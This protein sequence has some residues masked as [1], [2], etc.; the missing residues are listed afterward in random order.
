MIRGVLSGVFW[1]AV[2]VGLLAAVVSL[3][4]PLPRAPQVAQT[5][6]EAPAVP[7][8]AP[9]AAP[10]PEAVPAPVVE[11]VPAPATAAEPAPVPDG[12]ADPADAPVVMA[13][14]APEPEDS[15]APTPEVSAVASPEPAPEPAQPPQVLALPPQPQPAPVTGATD[16]PVPG[17]ADP[18]SAS[19]A[20]AGPPAVAAAD[21]GQPVPDAPGRP[22]LSE[23]PASLGA[24][25]SLGAV[26]PPLPAVDDVA[27]ASPPA[28]PP[29]TVPA[30]PADAPPQAL[31]P[32]PEPES[33][34][35]TAPPAATPAPGISVPRPEPGFAGAVDGVQSRRLPRIGGGPADEAAA[36]AE[37]E[38]VVP[39]RPERAL[40]RNARPFDNP[41]A[42]PP[43]ALLL[44][45][46]PASGVDLAA[47]A[48]GDLALT[49][50]ID[51]TAP[52]SAARAALWH[53]AGQE[54]ALLTSGLPQRGRAADYEV[55]LES[56]TGAFP[57]AL[58]LVDLPSGGMQG[59]RTAAAALVPALAARG[60]GLV[61]WDR[62]LNAAD[63]VARREGLPAAV[64]YRDLDAEAEAVPVIRRYLDR[65]AFK[66]QQD[67]RAVVIGRLRYETVAAL[68]EWALDG[69]AGTLALAP[70][71]ALLA[72]R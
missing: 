8:P 51:P 56:L 1:G 59:D 23:A 33:A 34:A 57:Q 47:L 58:A 22:A 42:K 50:V 43:F 49:L 4:S 67:G 69:R 41:A 32:A 30:E 13:A 53:A 36:E 12:A 44:L 72:P 40:D 62:G 60:F 48:A 27:Q 54:V 29:G 63:Q 35:D 39:L 14:P 45:D 11:P 10:A 68:L 9:V 20:V 17:A 6:T 61:T 25:P 2:S 52:E 55:A 26:V 66:A 64:I 15:P 19:P 24:N 7:D 31:P 16:M 28:A 37:P 71:S 65:A 70:V 3:V 18:A 46:D 21:E 38:A 5:S